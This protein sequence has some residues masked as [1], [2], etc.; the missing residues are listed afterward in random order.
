[1]FTED[2]SAFLQTGDFAVAATY[3]AAT[4]NVIHERQFLEQLGVQTSAPTALGRKSDFATVAQGQTITIGSTTWTILEFRHD[5]PGF[6][7]FTLL[8]LG[9]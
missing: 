1:M 3:Q 5:P 7:D 4:V 6:P 9:P 2:L 8:L